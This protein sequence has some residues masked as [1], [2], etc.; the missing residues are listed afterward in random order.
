MSNYEVADIDDRDSPWYGMTPVE[1]IQMLMFYIRCVLQGKG[2]D[3]WFSQLPADTFH[4]PFA[5]VN[6]AKLES[7]RT[8]LLAL[9][10]PTEPLSETQV[11]EFY[12][13]ALIGL[14][15]PYIMDNNG[16]RVSWFVK[17]LNNGWWYS[18]FLYSE[19]LHSQVLSQ[20][21]LYPM[22]YEP[23]GSVHGRWWSK[24]EA[25]VVPHI[26]NSRRTMMAL[27]GIATL[28][29]YI[30]N[31]G[32]LPCL[33]DQ[34]CVL[35]DSA[36]H[37]VSDD[38]ECRRNPKR[39]WSDMIQDLQLSAI[40]VLVQHKAEQSQTTEDLALQVTNRRNRCN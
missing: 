24:H 10:T 22:E 17:E 19:R 4:P 16:T 9:C 5:I 28:I 36:Q 1:C 38:A 29:K 37:C 18:V 23:G 13:S 7:F 40:D 6:N 20:D 21:A 15:L 12:K 2:C 31:K 30:R 33:R 14:K 8:V 35:W 25:D 34:C 3:G 39:T 27:D 26:I 11:S 32:K